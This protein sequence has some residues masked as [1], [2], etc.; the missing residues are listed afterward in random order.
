MMSSIDRRGFL[1][2]AG[3]L[4]VGMGL[5]VPCSISLLASEP[6]GGAP[7]A[8][9][10]GWRLGMQAW[11]FHQSTLCDA[12]DKTAA[13]R[14]HY[15]E[16]FPR[17]KLGGTWSHKLGVE[18]PANVRQALKAK[19]SDSGVKLVSYGVCGLSKDADQDRRVFEFAKDIG[20]ETIISE[21]T[22]DAFDAIDRLCEEYGINVAIHN[23]PEPSH[24]WNPD[25]VL[26]VCR[27]RSQRIGACADTGHWARSGL[28]PLECLKKLAGRIISFHLKDVN[29][30]GPK[31]Q[32][33]PYGTGVCDIQAL[34]AEVHRQGIKP[35][36]A[37]EYESNWGKSMPEIAQCVEFF[38]RAAANLVGKS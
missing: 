35:F 33:V 6:A 25:A 16:A 28:N 8:E 26:K 14:L 3:A 20:I 24:Y 38:D 27:G 34:L 21:P 18:L 29:Q 12:I 22:E 2:T 1:K 23:H 13:L 19:L 10:L 11:T 5:T 15:I 4:G 37:I 17:E 36:F 32:D 9:A 31:A 7:H 30:F